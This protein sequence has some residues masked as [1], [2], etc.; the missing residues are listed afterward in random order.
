M[1]FNGQ[2]LQDISESKGMKSWFKSI[3][4]LN[5]FTFNNSQNSSLKCNYDKITKDIYINYKS[6]ITNKDTF[7]TLAF[8]EQ[9][10]NFTS[11]YNLY[12]F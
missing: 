2:Q 1:L 4:N 6:D 7:K 5:S 9:L 11:F 12:Y 3:A 8:N 10:N